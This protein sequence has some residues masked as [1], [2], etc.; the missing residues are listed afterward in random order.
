MQINFASYFRDHSALSVE[1]CFYIYVLTF[2]MR[3]HNKMEN[4]IYKQFI[5]QERSI[6]K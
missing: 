6:V 2:L 1:K 5:L 3:I 4:K